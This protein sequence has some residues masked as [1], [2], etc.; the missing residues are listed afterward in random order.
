MADISK[1]REFHGLSRHTSERIYLGKLEMTDEEVLQWAEMIK[2]AYSEDIH[3]GLR[4][5]GSSYDVKA[6]AG[7]QITPGPQV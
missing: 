2:R 4:L 7:I 3:M 1:S 5:S 6:F